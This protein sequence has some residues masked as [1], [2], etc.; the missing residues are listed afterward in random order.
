M[1]DLITD[2][3]GEVYDTWQHGQGLPH[4]EDVADAILAKIGP[5]LGESQEKLMDSLDVA[6]RRATDAEESESNMRNLLASMVERYNMALDLV[7][8]A[9][10]TV[11]PPD[12]L[13]EDVAHRR[14]M[15]EDD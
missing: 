14:E 6:R 12:L 15:R 7:V 4:E 11:D 10:A 13:L 1:R 8:D 9:G 5:V 2:A 3:I